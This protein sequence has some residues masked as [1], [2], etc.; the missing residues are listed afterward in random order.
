MKHIDIKKNI[1]GFK[2]EIHWK[3]I[4]SGM[5]FL[6]CVGVIYDVYIYMYAEQQIRLT[7]TNMSKIDK[8]TSTGRVSVEDTF[9]VYKERKIV[10]DGI[11]EALS[12]N[13]TITI[14]NIATSSK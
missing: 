10:Y 7:D 13:K 3:L 1:S 11:I 5:F 9:E 6:L 14:K 4:I 8:A 2:P 12:A